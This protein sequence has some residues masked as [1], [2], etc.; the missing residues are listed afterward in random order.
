[1]KVFKYQVKEIF[2]GSRIAADGRRD[3]ANVG[4]DF[5]QRRMNVNVKR[6]HRENI[7]KVAVNPYRTNVENRVSS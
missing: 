2:R 4:G 3:M 1:M 5:F 7:N 6:T